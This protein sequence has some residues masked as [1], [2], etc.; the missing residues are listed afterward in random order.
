MQKLDEKSY[1]V[2]AAQI[3]LLLELK[4]I[5]DENHINYYLT[6]GTLIGAIRHNGFIPWDDDIDVA[7]ARND[8]EKFLSI[9]EPM[10]D[11]DYKLV[12]WRNSDDIA[13]PFSKLVIKGTH[14]KEKYSS[15]TGVN[16]CVFIDIFPID[17]SPENIWKQKIQWCK[18]WIIR[19]IVLKR[20]GF[21]IS[22]NKCIETLYSILAIISKVRSLKYWKIKFEKNARKYNSEEAQALVNYCGAYNLKRETFPREYVRNFTIHVFEDYKFSIPC[23]YDALLRNNY[24]DYMKLPPVEDQEGRHGIYMIDMGDYNIRSK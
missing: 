24:G 10:L 16:D 8:Y 18:C 7:M 2:R 4:R 22:H 21:K 13:V 11:T 14:F 23:E 9:C 20:F 17:C 3:D 5:C 15:N 12:N 19:K 1:L 6:G